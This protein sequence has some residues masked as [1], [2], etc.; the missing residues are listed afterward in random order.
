[1][2]LSHEHRPP[3]QTAHS[4]G[5]SEHA[6]PQLPQFSASLESSVQI[7]LH[8]TRGGRQGVAVA[9]AT[10]V[11][12]VAVA[13]PGESVAVPVPE[14]PPSEVDAV[15]EEVPP[16]ED[17]VTPPLLSGA[18]ACVPPEASLDPPERMVE[19]MVVLAPLPP[20]IPEALLCPPLPGFSLENLS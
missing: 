14:L 2:P 17:D 7:P 12:L 10:F 15:S 11:T 6:R 13:P 4:A 3:K 16:N 19:A 8:S 5:L 20:D 9:P 1:M 18:L